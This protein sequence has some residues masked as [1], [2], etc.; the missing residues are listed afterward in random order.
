MAFPDPCTRSSPTIISDILH[1][2]LLK[3]VSEAAR[4]AEGQFALGSMQL[5]VDSI[6]ATRFHLEVRHLTTSEL[7]LFA[8]ADFLIRLSQWT[9]S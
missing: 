7:I 5:F 2:P 4:L 6:L 1:R 3:L 8:N 9:H